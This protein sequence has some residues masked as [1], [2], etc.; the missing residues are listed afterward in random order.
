MLG[1]DSALR[2]HGSFAY[3]ISCTVQKLHLLWKFV[4]NI[5]LMNHYMLW[6]ESGM[7]PR[8]SCVEYLTHRASLF[9]HEAT[10]GR[11]DDEGSHIELIRV[12]FILRWVTE[13]GVTLRAILCPFLL[14]HSFWLVQCE[15]PVPYSLDSMLFSFTRGT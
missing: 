4:I 3:W 6:I 1:I 15:H 9:S 14:P 10:K 5:F 12:Q 8:G 2:R 7:S 13:V 11:M